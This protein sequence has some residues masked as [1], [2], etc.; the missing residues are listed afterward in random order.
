MNPTEKS[1]VQLRESIES[2]GV[3]RISLGINLAMA[4]RWK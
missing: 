1:N 4:M 3:A 2:K